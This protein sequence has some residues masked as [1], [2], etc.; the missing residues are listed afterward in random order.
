MVGDAG[1]CNSSAEPLLLLD[2]VEVPFISETLVNSAE[3]GTLLTDIAQLGDICM[4]I[5][6]SYMGDLVVSLSCPTGNTVILHQQSGGGTFL[7]DANDAYSALGPYSGTCFTYCFNADPDFGTWVDCARFGLTPN[8]VDVSEGYALAPGSYQSAESLDGFLGCPVN[9]IWT[10]TI[11]DMLAIDNGTLCNWCIGP[12]I[13]PDGAFAAFGPHLGTSNPDSSSWSGTNATT[14]TA[15]P[16]FAEAVITEAGPEEFTYSVIDTY[17]CVYDTT[18]S[19]LVVAAPSADAGPD[20][21]V[22]ADSVLLNALVSGADGVDLTFSWSPV[23]GL[24][25]PTTHAPNAFPAMD[26]EYTFTASVGGSAGCSATDVVHVSALGAPPFSINYTATT[27][28]LCASELG[29][30][31]YDWYNTGQFIAQ[32]LEP[33]LLTSE[34]GAWAAIGTDQQGCIAHSDTARICPE[35]TVEQNSGDLITQPGFASYSWTYNGESLAG[36]VTPLIQIQG[37]GLYVVT[38]T[39]SYGC[40]VSASVGVNDFSWID[41]LSTAEPIMTLFP[42]P[43]DGRFSVAFENAVAADA[44]LRV[45][46]MTGRSVHNERLGP[47]HGKAV[48]PIALVASPGA[49]F[50]ETRLDDRTL[51]QRIILH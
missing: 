33:C 2:I 3:P 50:V 7:G 16:T 28:L 25:D 35:L 17:G 19:V 15:Y 18:F 31:T 13:A 42:V 51:V 26:T 37:N 47:L 11:T 36:L 44:A 9:G 43:N 12:A 46:D 30:E 48:L 40:T 14:N 8:V 27:G 45:L 39:T 24:S 22:C 29:F 49:Y 20:L 4:E 21:S 34:P 10:L 38:I 6:H 32:S 1:G 41:E 5:E 23:V